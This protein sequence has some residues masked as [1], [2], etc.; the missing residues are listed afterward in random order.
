MKTFEIADMLVLHDLWV[1]DNTD[2]EYANLAGGN[3]QYDNLEYANLSGANLE[4]ANLTGAKLGCSNLQGANLAGANLW[5]A[6]LRKA[7]LRGAN[8]QGADLSRANLRMANLQGADLRDAK[9]RNVNL[10]GASLEGAN[11]DAVKDIIIAGSDPRGFLFYGTLGDG[12]VL[13][14]RAGCQL[15]IGIKE[16]TRH[17]KTRHIDKPIQQAACLDLVKQIKVAAKGKGWKINP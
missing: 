2:G 4:K 10:W 14:I 7:D 12:N 3:L 8:L 1:D 13:V 9:M 15:F 11:L 6:D 17:W 5:T 16:A